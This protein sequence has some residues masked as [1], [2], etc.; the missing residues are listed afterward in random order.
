M[1]EIKGYQYNGENITDFPDVSSYKQE[2]YQYGG[3]YIIIRKIDDG[4]H[5]LVLDNGADTDY[6]LLDEGESLT[7]KDYRG[8]MLVG[9]DTDTMMLERISWGLDDLDDYEVSETHEGTCRIVEE[10]YWSSHTSWDF[11][12]ENNEVEIFGSYKE[13]TQ[14][15]EDTESA[16]YYLTHNEVSRPNYIVVAGE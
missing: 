9:D 4:R 14:W 5:I 11:V 12:K 3:G 1:K 2:G 16:P 13:A 10:K 8:L 6:F 7:A 15:I